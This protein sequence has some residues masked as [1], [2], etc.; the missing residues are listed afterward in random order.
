MFSPEKDLASYSPTCPEAGFLKRFIWPFQKVT[1][2]IPF[3]NLPIET[4]A[5]PVAIS[6]AK[7]MTQSSHGLLVPWQT[8]SASQMLATQLTAMLAQ[9]VLNRC[10]PC[11]SFLRRMCATVGG[12]GGAV[13]G[14][15]GVRSGKA[16]M[17]EPV[18]NKASRKFHDVSR[19]VFRYHHSMICMH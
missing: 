9:Q 14:L 12:D 18:K 1:F 11:G 15:I 16:A 2:D 13:L 17:W 10:W 7:K 3:F 4:G 8:V 6:K 19:I 5:G